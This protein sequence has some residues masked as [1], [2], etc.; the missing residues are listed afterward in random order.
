MKIN[1]KSAI[2]RS[3]QMSEKYCVL[4]GLDLDYKLVKTQNV[5]NEEG[6][7]VEPFPQKYKYVGVS[8]TGIMY[9]C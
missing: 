4:Q 9:C 6:W 7:N 3:I 8:A 5:L 2:V 1:Q